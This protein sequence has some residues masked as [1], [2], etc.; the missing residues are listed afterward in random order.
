MDRYMN[1]LIDGCSN[2]S[3]DGWIDGWIVAC[4][5]ITASRTLAVILVELDV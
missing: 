1:G 3:M 2:G 4:P 5:S